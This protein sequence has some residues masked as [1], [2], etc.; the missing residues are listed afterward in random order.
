MKENR[1][2]ENEEIMFLGYNVPVVL[3]KVI[4]VKRKSIE[5]ELKFENMLAP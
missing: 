1:F 2:I 4:P 5:T 3:R